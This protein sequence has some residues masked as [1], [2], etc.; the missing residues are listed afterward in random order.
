VEASGLLKGPFF[1]SLFE[2]DTCKDVLT[3]TV[4]GPIADAS[5]PHRCSR[6]RRGAPRLQACFRRSVGGFHWQA[7]DT[8]FLQSRFAFACGD[9]HSP[10]QKRQ[11]P[12]PNK[13]P[14]GEHNGVPNPSGV[15]RG[16][17][18]TVEGT[19]TGLSPT[20]RSK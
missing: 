19:G 11:S 17:R 13:F 7:T 6:P 5:I 4:V 1:N 20:L 18:D 8:L 9:R 12:V 14:D 2:R 3:M 16:D 15:V 10:G